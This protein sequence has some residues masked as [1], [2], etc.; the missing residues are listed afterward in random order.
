MIVFDT[1]TQQP[2]DYITHG[3]SHRRIRYLKSCQIINTAFV[4]HRLQLLQ[5]TCH[6]LYDLI[7]LVGYSDC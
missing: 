7:Y 5:C 6:T 2:M 1:N 4:N 3:A